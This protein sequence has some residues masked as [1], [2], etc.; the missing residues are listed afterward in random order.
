MAAG[1]VCVYYIHTLV[2]SMLK[3]LLQYPGEKKPPTKPCSYIFKRLYIVW[4]SS[5]V[6]LSE[7][8]CSETSRSTNKK[9]TKC[10]E[11]YKS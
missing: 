9:V 11:D 5:C 3:I 10:G 1:W 4:H 6:P 2:K 7:M 8:R